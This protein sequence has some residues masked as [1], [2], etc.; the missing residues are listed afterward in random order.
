MI[1]NFDERLKSLSIVPSIFLATIVCISFYSFY[2]LNLKPIFV[3]VFAGIIFFTRF[4]IRLKEIKRLTFLLGLAFFICFLALSRYNYFVM[5]IRSLLSVKNAEELTV[6]LTGEA[7]PAG[8]YY[9]I[10]CRV[11]SLHDKNGNSFSARGN[12]NIF[13]PKSVI[14]QNLS[15][16]LSLIRSTNTRHANGLTNRNYDDC[17]IFVSGIVLRTKARYSKAEKGLDCFF[18]DKKLPYFIRWSSPIKQFRGLLRFNLMR[19]LFSWGAAGALL[20]A[21]ISADKNF[22]VS[23]VNNA[24]VNCGLAHVLAL[25]GMHVSIVSGTSKKLTERFFSTKISSIISLLCIFIFVFFAGSAP[26]LNRALGMATILILTRLLHIRISVFSAMSAMFLLHILVKPYEALSVSF[27]LSYGALAGI[28]LFAEALHTIG[29]GKI[30][31]SILS[32]FTAS[33]GAQ[34]FTLP[35]IAFTIKKCSL[36]GLVSSSLISP[37]IGYFLILGLSFIFISMLFTK[38]SVLLGLL[39]NYFYNFIMLFVNLFAGFFTFAIADNFTAIAC[40]IVPIAFGLTCMYF[41]NKIN[42]RRD[43]LAKSTL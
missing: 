19:L 36:I 12:A 41:Q 40:V 5:P 33:F 1:N 26:S 6:E 23:D 17:R 35:I 2:F 3:F 25:S 39:L 15:G 24:F 29:E 18:A 4:F 22:L 38:L 30:P 9:G 31:H 20:L 43:F 27:M 34:A 28:L 8:K 21:L 10:S 11:L 37:L 14:D 42:S 7:K 32:S 13:F 16:G